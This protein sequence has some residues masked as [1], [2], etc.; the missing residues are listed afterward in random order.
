MKEYPLLKPLKCV[1]IGSLLYKLTLCQK[2]PLFPKSSLLP[3]V[4]CDVTEE[5]S[6]GKQ[7]LDLYSNGVFHGEFCL[8]HAPRGWSTSA[9]TWEVLGK[10]LDW[11]GK[12]G[13]QGGI[14]GVQGA[15]T[16]KSSPKS[17]L[18][19]LFLLPS[20]ANATSPACGFSWLHFQPGWA[21]NHL[22]LLFPA[23]SSGSS[24]SLWISSSLTSCHPCC[25]TRASPAPSPGWVAPLCQ[26]LPGFI[27]CCKHEFGKGG[28]GKPFSARHFLA[29]GH[30]WERR[31]VTYQRIMGSKGWERKIERKIWDTDNP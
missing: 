3:W 1:V 21:A 18:C 28:A 22:L 29:Q 13:Y 19:S 24:W 23:P 12:P 8:L 14:M 4:I 15:T 30:L 17:S 9:P 20:S 16:P 26:P 2:K 7:F 25:A 31:V 5:F 10:G 6:V 27:P 11:E